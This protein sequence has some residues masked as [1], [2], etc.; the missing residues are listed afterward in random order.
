M[1]QQGILQAAPHCP[2][3]SAQLDGWTAAGHDSA[4]EPGCITVCIYCATVLRFGD[5]LLVLEQATDD[6]L[7]A[8]PPSDLLL[9][10]SVRAAVRQALDERARARGGA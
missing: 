1:K 3:C 8:L 4:P 5:G 7:A 6:E 2:V 9:V 10:L